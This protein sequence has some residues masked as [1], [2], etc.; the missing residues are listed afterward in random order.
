MNP[1]NNFQAANSKEHL[2]LDT[3]AKQD[4]CPKTCFDLFPGNS[5]SFSAEIEKYST[6]F[7]S[8]A[9]L[10]IPTAH[11]VDSTDANTTAYKDPVN[12]IKT[13]NKINDE[14]IAKKANKMW[15]TRDWTVSTTKQIKEL[16]NTRGEVGT[17]N[18]LTRV[19]KKKFME[20]WKSTIFASQVMV[21]LTPGAQNSIK[22]HKKACQWTDPISD[23][24]ITDG[25]SLLNEALKLMLMRPDVQT[26][27]Y[28]ELAKIRYQTLQV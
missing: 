15:G 17:A 10:N 23:E 4:F 9:L 19:G 12:V 25:R 7:G 6:Q 20:C 2:A 5:D 28:A 21:L 16:T 13:W 14:L 24:I 22:I 11:D 27:V 3:G 8:S 26:N 1:Y 18:A